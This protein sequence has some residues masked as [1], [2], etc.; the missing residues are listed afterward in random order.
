MDLQVK[1]CKS[2]FVCTHPLFYAS[3]GQTSKED[4]GAGGGGAGGGGEIRPHSHQ[5]C[6]RIVIF[7]LLGQPLLWDFC[8]S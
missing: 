5:K 6:K 1:L 8:P 3:F 2:S 7:L 4:G